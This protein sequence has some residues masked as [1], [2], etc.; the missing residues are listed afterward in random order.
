MRSRLLMIALA[1]VSILGCG[2]T[3]DLPTAPGGDGPP[4]PGATFTRVKS[5]IFTP[6]CAVAGCHDTFTAQEGLVLEAGVA[7][8]NLVSHPSTQSGLS[9]IEP[10]DPSRSYLFL[11]ISGAQSISGER[12]PQG[13]TPLTLEKQNLIRDWIRRGAPND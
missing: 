3:K 9:R 7:Y 13:R 8:T 12:M 6:T 2:E 1:A 4:D 5:E 11:K 10:G